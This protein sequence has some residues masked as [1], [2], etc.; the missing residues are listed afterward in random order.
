MN[1]TNAEAINLIIK[2]YTQP[3]CCWVGED[4][5]LPELI[6]FLKSQYVCVEDDIKY[7]LNED[8]KAFLHSYI[9]VC[10]KT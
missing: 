3:S 5:K 8:G 7:T 10:L 2:F 6:T 1:Y 9:R 4:V